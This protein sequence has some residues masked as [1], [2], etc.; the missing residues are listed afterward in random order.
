MHCPY[1]TL[2]FLTIFSFTACSDTEP[3]TA[4]SAPD[5]S[6]ALLGTWETVE[7]NIDYQTYQGGDTAYTETVQEADWGKVYGVK[8]P[9]TVFTSDGKLRRTYRMRNGEI[10]NITNGLWKPRGDSLLM[11]EP[12]VTYTYFPELTGDRLSL[13]GVL[14]LDRDG[15]RDDAYRG[16]FRLV[17]RT[18]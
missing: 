15:Q 4:P 12:N 1:L 2:L 5:L 10:A 9:S 17:S 16:I 14:D 13:T 11:I 3:A 18:R 7:Y 8:P 6:E